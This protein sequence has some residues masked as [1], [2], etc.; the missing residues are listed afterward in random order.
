MARENFYS[1]VLKKERERV[2]REMWEGKCDAD[3]GKN[4]S[5]KKFQG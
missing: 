5:V 3:P 4:Q 1:S 2:F